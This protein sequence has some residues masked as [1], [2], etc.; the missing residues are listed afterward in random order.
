[1]YP[2]RFLRDAFSEALDKALTR[3][4]VVHNGADPDLF[5]AERGINFRG[6]WCAGANTKVVLFVGAITPEKG[7][8]WLIKAVDLASKKTNV[9]VKLVVVGDARLWSKPKSGD[10]AAEYVSAVR[11]AAAK[12]DV[13]FTGP[14]ARDQMPSV[15]RAAD[16]VVVPSVVQEAHPTVVCEAMM[17]GKPVIASRVGGVPETIDDGKTGILVAAK[18]EHALAEAVLALVE[19]ERRRTQM[20]QAGR[21]RAMELFTW[22]R[23]ARRVE[24]VYRVAAQSTGRK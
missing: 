13:V 9:D 18:D 5:E 4:Y 11:D 6:K 22:E 17:A 16:V 19:D 1:L 8:Y 3:S 7:L 15:Y 10:R 14:V 12:I 24:S 2:S 23:S 21:K 20:G